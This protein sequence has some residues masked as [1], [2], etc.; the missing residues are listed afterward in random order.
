MKIFFK[1]VRFWMIVMMGTF[2]LSCIWCAYTFVWSA[3]MGQRLET[4]RKVLDVLS[5]LEQEALALQNSV[6]DMAVKA[7]T[8]NLI[9]DEIN[10][11]SEQAVVVTPV[12]VGKYRLHRAEL[13]LVSERDAPH[14]V[15][16]ALEGVQALPIRLGSIT[17]SVDDQNRLTGTFQ[18]HWVEEL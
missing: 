18:F 12:L 6:G 9:Y 13:S 14:S 17:L 11:I 5:V 8:S 16:D 7:S 15:L 3:K 4:D 2:A 1:S 10:R